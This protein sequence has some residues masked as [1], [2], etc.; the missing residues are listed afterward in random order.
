MALIND[1]S[2]YIKVYADGRYEVYASQESRETLKEHTDSSK[3]IKKYN[4]LMKRCESKFN[5][6]LEKNGITITKLNAKKIF[7]E[8]PTLAK[9][10][11]E[12]SCICNEL[13]CYEYDLHVANGPHHEF[14]IIEKYFDDVKDTIPTIIEKGKV[15]IE[16]KTIDEAYDK[17]KKLKRFGDTID[18]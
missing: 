6:Y 5:A 18:C 13:S 2:N 16:S 7:E 11:D 10:N 1:I 4:E 14:P 3:I 8:H 9:L 12:C 15:S 17:L